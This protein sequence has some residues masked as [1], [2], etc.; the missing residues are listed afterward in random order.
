MF[1]FKFFMPAL[2]FA[3][4]MLFAQTNNAQAVFA[5]SAITQN[6]SFFGSGILTGGPDGGGAFLSNTSDPPTLLGSITFGFGVSLFDGVGDDF[7]LFDVT[8]SIDEIYDV[9]LSGDGVSFTSIGT[10][11]TLVNG[12][13]I[14]GAFAGVF[15]FIRVTNTSTVNSAD[16]DAAEGFNVAS[17]VSVVPLPAALPL[18]GTGLALMGFIGWRRKRKIA[19][20]A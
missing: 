4:A 11:T 18:F 14:N 13:D 5:T 12:I 10:F 8:Q 15:S 1:K 16:L 2:L 3:S 17:G 7:E 6:V 9:A 19:A 20:P